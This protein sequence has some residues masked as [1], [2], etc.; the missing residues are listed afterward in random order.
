MGDTDTWFL[1]VQH[2]RA[3]RTDVTEFEDLTTAA[4][5]YSET[6]RR[7]KDRF[8]GGRSGVDVL[9][10]GASSIEVV[11]QRYPSYFSNLRSRSEKV[12]KLLASLPAVPAT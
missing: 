9:L 8:R 4:A 12:R 6:E 11:K 7:Y 1:L 10:V 3:G 2:E 5:A